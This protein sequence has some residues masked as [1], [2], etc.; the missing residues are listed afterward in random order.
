MPFFHQHNW[1]TGEY[2]P[3]I[4]NTWDDGVGIINYRGWG[5]GNG[6]HKPYFHKEELEALTKAQEKI[7]S[8][9]NNL[10]E[11]NNQYKQ[12]KAH[13]ASKP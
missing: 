1:E 11:Q 5:D 13:T 10:K 4:P 7:V 9:N 6:W 8:E 12:A 2:N 3:T